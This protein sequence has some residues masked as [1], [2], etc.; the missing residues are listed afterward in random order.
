MMMLED[1]RLALRQICRAMGLSANAATVVSLIILG[2]ALNAVALHAVKYMGVGRHAHREPIALRSAARTEIKVVRT[3]M[4]TTLK[5]ISNGRRWCLAQQTTTDQRTKDYHVA[6]GVSWT[7]P[8]GSDV[9]DVMF[10]S[11]SGPKLAVAVVQ[12]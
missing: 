7:A 11:K 6:L 2:V 8:A 12:C 9:C 5:K 10:V 4:V 1:L 3:V